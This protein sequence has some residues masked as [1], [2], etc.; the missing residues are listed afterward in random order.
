ME[1][2][3]PERQQRQDGSTTARLLRDY[4]L[5]GD[6]AAR[7]RL[8]ELHLPLVDALA[9]RHARAPGEYDDLYQAGCIGLINAIDR[10]DLHRGSELEAFAVPHITGEIRRHRRDRDG[11]V[12]LPRPVI[13][14]RVPAL[15]AHAALA[16]K[17]GHAPTPAQVAAAVGAPEADVALALDAGR[18][19]MALELAEDDAAAGADAG[20]EAAEERL[21][22]A[23]AFGELDERERRLLYLRYVRDL[24]AGEVA[25]ELG[26]SARQLSRAT[27]AA[28]AKLRR[29]LEGA[30]VA[31]A[32]A[33]V[34]GPRDDA[35]G[36]PSG[37]AFLRLP[38]TLHAQLAAAAR[39]EEV[40]LNRYVV[41][42]LAAALDPARAAAGGRGGRRRRGRAFT[43]RRSD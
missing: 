25:R 21:T 30:P 36:A 14:L 3:G 31:P 5:R 2:P 23:E 9:R 8:V 29:G 41:A 1:R 12:R 10:F 16:A 28:L 19:S 35:G 15:R 40:S 17:L 38:R 42:A 33:D 37:R 20:L 43:R 34:P 13:E 7:Q 11:S 18:A 22:L 39:Q 26:L 27:S 24:Q 6:T 32:P 4:H